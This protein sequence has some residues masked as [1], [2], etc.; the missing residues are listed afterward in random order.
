MLLDIR[1]LAAVAV[2]TTIF[3]S[4]LGLLLFSTRRTYPGF[5]RWTLAN[6]FTA[7]S[8]FLLVL[9]GIAPGFLSILVANALGIVAAILF[10]EGVREFCG[11]KPLFWPIYAAAGL[12]LLAFS[13]FEFVVD[14]INS[15]TLI[16][17]PFLAGVAFLNAT[18]LFRNLMPGR[19]LGLIFSGVSYLVIGVVDIIRAIY[20]FL[21]PRQD[22][23]APSA[24]NSVYYLGSVLAVIGWSFGFIVLTNDRLIAD[25]KDAEQRTAA[26]NRQLEKALGEASD[27]AS[28]ATRADA[29][30]SDFLSSVS[31]EIRTPMNGVIG[32]TDLLLETGLTPE[33][34][35]YVETIAFSGQS[36][37]ALVN[38]L[39]DLSK[40]E[41]GKLTVEMIEFDPREALRDLLKFFAPHAQEK[42]LALRCDGLEK[43]PEKLAG[44]PIRFRQILTNL[45]SNAIKF[46]SQGEVVLTIRSVEPSDGEVLVGFEVADTGIGMNTA[47]VARLFQRFEQAD[48]TVARKYG[49][50]GLGL[51]IVKSLVDMMGGEIHVISEPSLGTAFRF[52]L[53]FQESMGSATLPFVHEPA[54]RRAS[55]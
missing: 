29:A 52:T 28:K 31:H 13:Y 34:R 1:T 17:T 11:L 32:M 44:D 22:L 51:A 9:R 18:M 46:T 47:T 10:L 16:I 6:L 33:Q 2:L 19:R 20:V 35:D 5:G 43:L 45:V 55:S 12:T 24:V 39:L 50:T 49:G 14:D 21:G 53:R 40:I 36:L 23:F 27:E 7:V 8:I 4:A 25:L 37:L 38:N 48:E 54:P 42:H 15:R 3:L 26:A 41:A 30:K